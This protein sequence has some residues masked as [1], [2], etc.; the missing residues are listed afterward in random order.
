MKNITDFTDE[1]LYQEQNRRRKL[2]DDEM[3]NNQENCKHQIIGFLHLSE[4]HDDNSGRDALTFEFDKSCKICHKHIETL[5]MTTYTAE[6]EMEF[7]IGLE[8]LCRKYGK[9]WRK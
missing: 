6:G 5:F 9:V 4:E 3:K 7:K 8:D 2:K 1:E